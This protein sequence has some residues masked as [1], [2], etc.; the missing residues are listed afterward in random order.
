MWCSIIQYSC[1]YL[2]SWMLRPGHI[3]IF[4]EGWYSCCWQ[5]PKL[6]FTNQKK[7]TC[8]FLGNSI[9]FSWNFAIVQQPSMLY[10]R[11]VSSCGQFSRS[12]IEVLGPQNHEESSPKSQESWW[13]RIQNPENQPNLK[14]IASYWSI[15]SVMFIFKLPCEP[16]QILGS[17]THF[18]PW[19][20]QI[21]PGPWP[22]NSILT[23]PG[24]V[25]QSKLFKFK[26]E[27]AKP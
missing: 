22:H 18:D 26:L 11:T 9:P 16:R 8:N 25:S 7:S 24:H 12:W 6:P 4:H 13:L 17:L 14:Q 19:R 15:L 3:L 27:S 1:V 10:I 21:R 23:F 20:N 2:Y 5:T